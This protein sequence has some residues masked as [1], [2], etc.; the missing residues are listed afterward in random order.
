MAKKIKWRIAEGLLIVAF[1]LV[2]LFVFVNSDRFPLPANESSAVGSLRTLYAAN[3]EYTKDH[4]EEGYP[5]KLSELSQRLDNSGQQDVPKWVIDPA[6]AAGT[7]FGYA[8]AYNPRS[9]NGG[10]KI[11]AYEINAEPIEP[12]KYGKHHFFMDETGVIRMSENS[13]ANSKDPALH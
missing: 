13:P 8:F 5:K 11:D 10:E 4:P 12:G 7:R 9:S 3:A 1:V 6:L 2:A